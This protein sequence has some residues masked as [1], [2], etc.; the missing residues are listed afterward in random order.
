MAQYNDLN[1]LTL[2][3]KGLAVEVKKAVTEELVK[4]E[5]ASYEVRLRAKIKPLIERISFKG[6]ESIR[7]AMKMRDEVHVFL[8]WDDGSKPVAKELK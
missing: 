3:K 1:M 6:I 4:E 2:L 5:M 7:D 8:Q